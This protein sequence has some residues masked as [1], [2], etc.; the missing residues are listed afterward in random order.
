MDLGRGLLLDDP[1]N[2]Q[3]SE[4]I[5]ASSTL[6][7]DIGR[8]DPDEE[9]IWMFRNR[10]VMVEEP[11]TANLDEV[12][13]GVKYEVLNLERM[14]VDMKRDVELLE[15][16]ESLAGC[17]REPIPRE[18]RVLVWRR[19]QG[20]CVVCGSTQKLEFDHII[21][22]AKGGS[23]T[24]RNIQLLCESCNREKAVAI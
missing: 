3:A 9:Q 21:P 17:V 13:L 12:A 10:L 16:G 15:K 7:R 18:V 23:N 2:R 19:D 1:G 6:E 11:C 20:R 22:L 8:P 4:P 14:F 5:R 24:E